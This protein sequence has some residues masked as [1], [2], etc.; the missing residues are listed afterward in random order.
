MGLDASIYALTPEGQ[1]ITLGR[2]RKSTAYP[3]LELVY[4]KPLDS[5]VASPFYDSVELYP[6]FIKSVQPP[7]D[8]EAWVLW[9]AGACRTIG[10]DVIERMSQANRNGWT[11][12]LQWD[13]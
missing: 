11:V 1:A 9:L 7:A 2:Y 6:A 4:E 10:E 5:I 12:H 8:Y 13:C 3:V